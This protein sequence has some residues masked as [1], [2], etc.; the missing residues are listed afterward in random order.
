MV[1]DFNRRLYKH[2]L[3]RHRQGLLVELAFL[4]ADYDEAGMAYVTRMVRD[5]S[6]QAVTPAE[7]ARI[8]AIIREEYSLRHMQ[9]PTAASDEDLRQMM[10]TLRNRKK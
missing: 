1:T 8:A 2:L 6:E 4:A 10:E 3:D 9:D 5:V 7:A